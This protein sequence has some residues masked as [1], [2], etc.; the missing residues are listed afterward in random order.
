MRREAE[1]RGFT[2]ARR[3]VILGDGAQWIWRIAA[4]DYPG[5]IQI[6]DLWHA[7]EHLWQGAR[8]LCDAHPAQV[9]AWAHAR[10]DDLEQ[11]RLDGL[12]AT[13]R[14]HADT[15]EPA[16]KCADYIDKNR[17]RMRYPDFRA[18]GLCVGSGVVESG[19]KSIVGSRLKQSGMRW[20]VNG[21]NSIL[22]LRCCVLSGGYEDF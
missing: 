7:K 12:L 14:T 15:C 2:L 18:Q 3:R 10:C 11:G 22:A 9:E 5:A 6:V 20:T 1:R 8:A 19:C 13:L 17:S 4:E 21:A 16:G